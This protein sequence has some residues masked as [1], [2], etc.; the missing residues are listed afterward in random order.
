MEAMGVAWPC[1]SKSSVA[2]FAF[3]VGY[4][5]PQGFVIIGPTVDVVTKDLFTQKE[6]SD[7][8]PDTFIAASADNRYYAGYYANDSFLMF[9]ID[10]SEAAS[11]IKINQKLTDMW[12]DPWTG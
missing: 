6:W 8:N 7:L 12:A 4:A 9:V 5:A 1:M 10:K 11:F 3:G 2:T